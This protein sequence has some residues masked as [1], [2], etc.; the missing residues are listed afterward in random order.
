MDIS[1]AICTYNGEA[2][3]P[4]VLDRLASQSIDSSLSWEVIVVDNNSCDRT[5]HVVGCC[6]SLPKLGNRLRYVFESEQGLAYARRR[7]VQ[8]AKS[9][10][11]AFLDDDNL[12]A[13]DWLQ[14]AYDFSQHHPEAGAYGSKIIGKYEVSPPPDFD[15]IACF[16]AVIDRGSHPFRYDKLAQWLFPA[17]A[18]FVVRKKAWRSAVIDRPALAGVS[19]DCLNSKGED[20]ETFSY[21]RKGGWQIW[22][23]PEMCIEHV[24]NKNRLTQAYLIRLFRGVGLSRYHTRTIRF[25]AWQRFP[26][27]IAYAF[28]DAIQLLTYK[29]RVGKNCSS[30]VEQCELTLLRYS[31]ISPA[32]YFVQVARRGLLSRQNYGHSSHNST[33]IV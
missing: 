25:K 16:L 19:G 3:L 22:H 15:R 32:Y 4:E 31:L 18:G 8:E 10:L 12:P 13:V 6:Q 29:M 14:S 33:H 26:A 1:V 23:N 2:R 17:G 30:V 28:R 20:I 21:L 9:E 24:I 11:I 7:A 27:V 5:A